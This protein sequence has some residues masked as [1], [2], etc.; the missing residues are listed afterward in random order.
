MKRREVL[1]GLIAAGLMPVGASAATKRQLLMVVQRGCVFC[2]A[3]RREVGPGYSDHPIGR[4]LPLL[5]VDIDGPWP[6]GLVL[7]R[8]PQVTPTFILL[9][10]GVE[11]GRIEG[12]PGAD[13]F[14]TELGGLAKGSRRHPDAATRLR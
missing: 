8:S 13:D 11:L 14:W 1:G 4:K 7:A 9:N 10:G 3:W 2:A 12:Y 5:E 6:N